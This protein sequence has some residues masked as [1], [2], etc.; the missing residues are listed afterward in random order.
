[1]SNPISIS[2]RIEALCE[3]AVAAGDDDMASMCRLVAEHEL[4]DS[5]TGALIE[6][7]DMFSRDASGPMVA[8]VRAMVASMNEGADEGHVW[9]VGRKVYA[10]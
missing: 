7:E 1:M 2:D 9:I 3:E 6:P 4:Y 5:D 10:A 8:Y